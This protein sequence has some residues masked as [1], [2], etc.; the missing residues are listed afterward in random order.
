V[1]SQQEKQFNFEVPDDL[2]MDGGVRAPILTFKIS[3]FEETSIKIYLNS[4]EIISHT[5][6]NGVRMGWWEAFQF[7]P[8]LNSFGNP[9]PLK[10]T[11]NTQGNC[12]ISDVVLW[13][14]I[15]K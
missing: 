8:A 9:T 13:Y 3:A 4:Q 5:F 10:F 6:P 2:S 11:C 14:Q 15:N 1:N 12:S 7:L